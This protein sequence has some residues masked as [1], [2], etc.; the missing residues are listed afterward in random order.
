VL[1]GKVAL[2]TYSFNLIVDFEIFIYCF[3]F[4]DDYHDDF[5]T[6]ID[7][8]PKSDRLF[9]CG[10]DTNVGGRQVTMEAL[11][12]PLSTLG[13]SE[14]QNIMKES[15][16]KMDDSP[17]CNGFIAENTANCHVVEAKN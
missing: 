15:P 13:I 7:W 14:K 16:E 6:G 4:R 11:S 8:E 5:V 3:S 17:Q 2:C 9:S 1:D 12:S 10:W